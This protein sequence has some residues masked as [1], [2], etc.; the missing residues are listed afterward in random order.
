MQNVNKELWKMT[1]FM[2]FG[3]IFPNLWGESK[4]INQSHGHVDGPSPLTTSTTM[5][6]EL[7]VCV[8]RHRVLFVKQDANVNWMYCST[9]IQKYI[10][11]L[12]WY[13]FNSSI[14]RW[15]SPSVPT[16]WRGVVYPK[17]PLLFLQRHDEN[18]TFYMGRWV[19]FSRFL[20]KLFFFHFQISGLSFRWNINHEYTTNVQSLSWVFCFSPDCF[21]QY[22][23]SILTCCL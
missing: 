2:V 4:R 11:S 16:F 22:F 12:W 10:Q 15:N 6:D 9:N 1:L 13:S 17:T 8:S 19:C 5:A 21:C 14:R 7:I 18:K 23:Y 3:V 20:F